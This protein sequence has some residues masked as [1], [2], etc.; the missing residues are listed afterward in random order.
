MD[1]Y[2]KQQKKM[3]PRMKASAHQQNNLWGRLSLST[4]SLYLTIQMISV[5]LEDV[6]ENHTCE[7]HSWYIQTPYRPLYFSIF[8]F[9]ENNIN[10]NIPHSSWFPV[11]VEYKLILGR[12]HLK[13]TCECM[14]QTLVNML[15]CPKTQIKVGELSH[16]W[17]LI[18]RG[19]PGP[20]KPL[21]SLV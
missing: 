20:L 1:W 16:L 2:R 10:G 21:Y 3:F 8:F 5:R 19:A 11:S 4:I 12:L 18:L 7:K 6:K 17:L 15:H 14:N 13:C 9:L